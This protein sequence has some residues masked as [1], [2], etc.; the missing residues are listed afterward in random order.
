MTM[1]LK[2]LLTNLQQILAIIKCVSLLRMIVLW[3]QTGATRTST[4]IPSRGRVQSFQAGFAHFSQRF[5][6]NFRNFFDG[7]LLQCKLKPLGH[8]N[9]LGVKVLIF[10]ALSHNEALLPVQVGSGTG[11]KQIFPESYQLIIWKTAKNCT[12]IGQRK[13]TTSWKFTTGTGPSGPVQ[14]SI[15]VHLGRTA[16]TTPKPST[17]FGSKM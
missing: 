8:H 5:F 11:S 10:Y 14:M 4:T 1:L 3:G 17:R 15:S 9:F 13:F 7:S 16:R 6:E 2:L 12:N